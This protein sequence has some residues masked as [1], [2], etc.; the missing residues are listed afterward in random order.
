LLFDPAVGFPILWI[1]FF[2]RGRPGTV[3]AEAGKGLASWDSENFSIAAG[4]KAM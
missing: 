4:G 3:R 1:R 2:L